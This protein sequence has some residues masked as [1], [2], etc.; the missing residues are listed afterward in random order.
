MLRKVILL[1]GLPG[2]GELGDQVSVRPGF[3][4]NYLI[5]RGKALPANSTNLE[6]FKKQ[7]K[8]LAAEENKRKAEAEE[9]AAKLAEVKLN[10]TMAATP[11][12]TLYGSLDVARV[13]EEFGSK[14]FEVSKQEINLPSGHIKTVGDFVAKVKLGFGLDVEVPVSIKAAGEGVE[15]LS[16]AVSGRK[17]KA[18]EEAGSEAKKIDGVEPQGKRQSSES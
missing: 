10:F 9:R 16:S 14:G 13:C 15:Q 8:Q 4:R 17:E 18:A 7:K 6:Y 5:P 11:E 12:G 3:A 1:A 2:Y